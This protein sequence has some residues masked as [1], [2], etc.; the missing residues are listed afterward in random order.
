M[1]LY[2][3]E[4]GTPN[5]PSLVFLHGIG[6]SGWMW[7]RQ[8]AA[9]AGFHCLT[10]DLPGHGK[11]NRK[12]WV[13]LADTAGQVAA[14]IRGR[15][16]AGRAHV[17]GLSL[18]GYVALSLLEGH[19]GVLDR[20]VISGVTAAPMPNRVLLPVQLGLMSLLMK[21]RW[22]MSL[23]ARS[24]GLPPDMKAAFIEA[25]LAMSMKAYRRIWQE[26]VQYRVSPGL[27]HVTT[28]TLITAGSRESEIIRQA[29][30]TISS[31]MPNAEGRLAP[32]LGHGWNIEAPDLF[33]TMVRAW[34][35]GTP[36]P[37]RLEVVHG[38]CV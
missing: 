32:E 4:A 2:V 29:V 16:T 28:P 36:L 17:V 37:E 11:S 22:Y 20:A 12:P 13:S 21:R 33:S 8:V 15:A 27:R 34:I 18:G 10:V 5:A 26:G 35:T 25:L 24:A 14:L 19:A 23:Q 1:P 7:E 3:S 38:T 30:G 6:T 9:L 31:M